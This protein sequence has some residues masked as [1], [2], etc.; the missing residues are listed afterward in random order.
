MRLFSRTVT[1]LSAVLLAGSVSAL[2]TGCSSTSDTTTGLQSQLPGTYSLRTVN[3]AG[4]PYSL[5]QDDTGATVAIASDVF[6]F[7]SDG[8]FTE[9]ISET[10]TPSGGTATTNSGTDAGTWRLSGTTV[11]LTFTDQSTL[12]GAFA[13]GT[14]ITFVGNGLTAV[15]QK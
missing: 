15:Y 10:S 12:T 9:A 5:G 13:S 2:A 7:T 6:T 11:T 4:L 14:T 3:G 1:T 8:S